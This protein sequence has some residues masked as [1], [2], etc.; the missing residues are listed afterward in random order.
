MHKWQDVR[1][2]PQDIGRAR[3]HFE[4]EARVGPE[5]GEGNCADLEIG[6]WRLEIGREKIGRDAFARVQAI[7]IAIVQR[8]ERAD[9]FARV[10]FR[11]RR[12]RASGAASVNPN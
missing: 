6:D 12:L 3:E 11:T 10:N 5:A 1:G 2:H 9:E 8:K 7:V 4:R